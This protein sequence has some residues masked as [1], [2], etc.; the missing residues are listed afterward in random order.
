MDLYPCTNSALIIRFQ[1]VSFSRHIVLSLG[2]LCCPSTNS[3]LKL[4]ELDQ[5]ANGEPPLAAEAVLDI[6]LGDG[7]QILPFPEVTADIY[8]VGL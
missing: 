6:Y 4:S 5:P 7:D 2:G 1:L 8:P 3:F